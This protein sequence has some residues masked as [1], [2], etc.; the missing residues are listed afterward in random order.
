MALKAWASN[1]WSA[2]FPGDYLINGDTVV[3]RSVHLATKIPQPAVAANG[4]EVA[5]STTAATS[6]AAATVSADDAAGLAK[7]AARLDALDESL[8]AEGKRLTG[9]GGVRGR[10]DAL[11]AALGLA[12]GAGPE[13]V[14]TGAPTQGLL[15][16][17]GGS[18]ELLSCVLGFSDF[19]GRARVRTASQGAHALFSGAQEVVGQKWQGEGLPQIE[20]RPKGLASQ[21]GGCGKHAK[22]LTFLVPKA[23]VKAVTLKK[24]DEVFFRPPM[25][26]SHFDAD[27][28]WPRARVKEV[29]GAQRFTRLRSM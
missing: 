15:E 3:D 18:C 11:V 12:R 1:P 9:R 28:D 2:T 23:S 4:A 22:A 6:P 25:L 27:Q 10:A 13:R 5:A 8:A 19:K 24:G 14:C 17:L 16:A 21:P 7:L 20:V 26:F 29:N